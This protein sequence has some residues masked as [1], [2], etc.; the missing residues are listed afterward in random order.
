MGPIEWTGAMINGSRGI[1]D[2]TEDRRP[3]GV[4]SGLTRSR[5]PPIRPGVK[6]RLGDD[7]DD[8]L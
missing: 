2:V 1:R 4:T 3:N 6:D 5:K 8:M 7:A